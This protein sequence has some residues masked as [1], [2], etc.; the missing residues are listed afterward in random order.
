MSKA[1]STSIVFCVAL[2]FVCVALQAQ[3]P[4]G[5]ILGTVTDSSGAVIPQATITITNK[6]TGNPRNLTANAEGLFSAPALPA[7]DYEVRGERE[8]FRT[9]VR[10]ASVLAGSD[11]TVNLALT[12]G[13]SKEVVTVEAA[14]AQI[15]YD[16]HT[17]AGSIERN[18]IQELPLNGRSFVQLATLEPGV[19][20]TA[21]ASSTRNSPISVSV[22][23]GNGGSTLLTLDGLKIMDEY[24][25]TGT[26]INFSQEMVQEFQL[27]SVNF[28]ISTGITSTGAINI[29]TRSG[30]NDVH[31]SA[32]F[33]Y[34]DHSMAAYPA[35][36][37]ST[38]NPDP[39]FARRD[40]GFW[41]GGPIIKDKL[42]FF[43]DY[44]R[45]S[46]VQAVTVAGDLASL[47]N[48]TGIY[49][50]PQTYRSLNVR[51]DYRLSTKNTIFAR[52]THDG[53]TSFGQNAGT[54]PIPSNWLNNDNWSDQTALG[55]T[56]IFTANL[57]NDVRFGYN[58]W[59][60]NNPIATPEQC[61]FPCVGSGL[62]STTL[63][64]SSLA[65]GNNFNAPQNRIQR[66]LN[67]VDSLS[68]QK[69]SHRI[70]A[71][72]DIEY[73]YY[74]FNWSFCAP[75][76]LD[77][78][79][80]ENF[81]TNVG[82]ANIATYLPGLPT[83]INTTADLLNLPVYNISPALYGGI[84]IGPSITPGPY[85][86]GPDRRNIRPRFFVQ[87]T[88]K[89]REGLTVNYGL[90]YERESGL[91]NSDISKPAFLAPIY[92]AGGLTPTK[93][94]NFDFAP[95][96]GFA[97]SLGKSGKTVIRGGAGMY[98]DTLPI[99]WRSRENGALGP[100]GNGRV[101]ISAGSFKNIFPGIVSFNTTTKAATPIAVGDPLPVLTYTN[102]TLGQFMQIYN[103][104][105]GT[106]QQSVSPS[107]V[108]SS[109]AYTTTDL[110]ILKSASE[111]YPQN[112]PL[113][114]S[115][116]TSIGAQRDLGHGMVLTA[117]WARRQFENTSLGEVDLN[118]FSSAA[119]P[120]IPKCTGTQASVVGFECSTGA[121]TVWTTQGRSI[122]EGLLMKLNKR[123]ARYQFQA[124]YALQNGN[125]EAVVN[126]NNYSQGY[127]P[128]L[129]RHNMNVSGVI[130]LKFGVELGFN[131]SI[132]SRTPVQPTTPG[133]DPSHTGAVASG[134]LPGNS[135]RCYGLTC[136]KADF[137]KAVLAA[138][139][140]VRPATLP[141]DYQFGDPTFS[142]D[143]RLTKNFVYKEHYKLAVFGEFF[144]AFNIANLT[145]YS[146]SIG[147]SFGQPTQRAAQSF[148]S[149]GPRAIQV[150]ARLNF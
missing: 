46:Q 139:N 25:G 14:S 38:L 84:G 86:F 56:T 23:G 21:G 4:T 5:T 62:P 138:Y 134:P 101:T 113:T 142:Q 109:G 7:G 63:L 81:T 29:V 118:H 41:I 17:I 95:S 97:Y 50:S 135:Y 144:N 127:G 9:T 100:V 71:G 57:V 31:G 145:G 76:C 28:D 68:W 112:M 129:P 89:V 26:Q 32:F 30:G 83:K 140:G 150:G 77:A 11:T 126:L 122:Y 49:S 137:E 93:I 87:D 34:R 143:F 133:I 96:F 39:Y 54:P 136:D 18:S 10:D 35:L 48:L 16:N 117:D 110:D 102:M 149:G 108:P 78:V 111:L 19:T 27:S 55:L 59:R 44:E 123:G 79:T 147:P 72:A 24:D 12:V 60:S 65:V 66:N 88:W 37:R 42:F 58:Y 33:Y 67:F 124:S 13:A 116:Q 141:T 132:I 40:P 128:Y 114:R 1:I 148:L 3:A 91:F 107:T 47:S 94:N 120:V 130:N 69:G 85:N 22:L 99:Y 43:F 115:Y 45:Q 146:F 52:Y 8:G 51:F 121:I 6:A 36:K 20:V 2:L 119:G 106:I 98:W 64:G 75:A 131:S 82:A 61:Q 15:N 70:R 53:N 104:Q 105:F 103:A 80:T 73:A 92:G 125:T 90:G 74:F